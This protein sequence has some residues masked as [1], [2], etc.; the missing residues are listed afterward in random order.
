MKNIEIFKYIITSLVFYSITLTPIS[1]FSAQ[2]IDFYQ[3]PSFLAAQ[4]PPLVM[5]VMGKNHKLFYEAYN[6]ASDLN[7]DGTIDVGYCGESEPFTDNNHNDHWDPGEPFTDRNKDGKW[8]GGFDYYGY[9]DSYKC[10]RYSTSKK[11]FEPVAAPL[12]K[13]QPT[14][15][16]TGVNKN[17]WSGDFLNYLTMSR[18][19]TLRKVLYGG[20]RSKDSA[21][22]TVLERVF[23]PQDAHSWGKEYKSIAKDGYDIR[24]YTPLLLPAPN[25]RHLFASTTLSDSGPPVLRVLPDN[26]HRIWSWVAKEGPVVDDTLEVKAG[27]HPKHPGN[28][29]EFTEFVNYYT[30]KG[31]LQGRRTAASSHFNGRIDGS[32][33]PFGSKNPYL[34]LF[35]GDLNITPSNEGFYQF[36]VCGSH[37]VEV[38]ID[39]KFTAG[40][41]PK[42]DKRKCSAYSDYIF[43]SAGLHKVEFRHENAYPSTGNYSLKWMM[44]K[45]IGALPAIFPQTVPSSSF[46]SDGDG[47]SDLIQTIFDTTNKIDSTISDYIVRIEVCNS[48]LPEKNCKRYPEGSFKPVGL[49]QKYGED[50]KMFFGLMTGSYDKNMS[51][52]V[53]RKNISSFTDE[54]NNK[55]GQFQTPTDGGIIETINKLRIADFH[56]GS[57]TYRK[58]WVT[59]RPMREAEFIDWGNPL[60][61]MMYETVRYF[62]GKP[63]PTSIFNSKTPFFDNKLKLP[64][65]A[66]TSPYNTFN[67]CSPPFMLLLSDIYPTFDSDQLP[68]SNFTS[69]RPLPSNDFTT[70]A[71]NTDIMNVSVLA[72]KISNEETMNG[73]FFIGQNGVTYDGACT[74]KTITSLGNIRG[75]CPEEPTKEGSYYAAAVAYY[76][77]KY[78]INSKAEGAQRITTYSVALASP[79][80]HINIA[81]NTGTTLSPDIHQVTLIP[82]AKSI[83]GSKI[84]PDK[85]EFQPTNTIVDFFVEEITPTYGKFRVNFED[86]EQGA[87]HDM[88]AIV[89]YEYT[90]KHGYV[91]IT[92]KCSYAAGSMIQH[93]G[94]IISGTTNDGIYLEVRDSD[95]DALK[96][97]DYFLDTPPGI[98]PGGSGWND[99]TALPI[100]NSR[101]FYPKTSHKRTAFIKNPL[102]YAAKW[103]GFR[104][105]DTPDEDINN[106]KKLDAGEDLNHNGK[107]DYLSDPIPNI[108]SEWDSDGNNLPD[109]YFYVVS[110]LKLEE[111]LSQSFA[112]MLA[113]ASSGSAASIISN[114]RSGEGAVYQSVFYPEFKDSSGNTIKWAGKIQAFLVDQHGNMRVDMYRNNSGTIV[115]DF[116]GGFGFK[117]LNLK[118]EDLNLNGTRDIGLDEDINHNSVL[119]PGEDLNHN[120]KLDHNIDEPDYD[121]DG[122][123]DYRD[124]IAVFQNGS[125]SLWDDANENGL[126]DD[127]DNIK[128]NPD[129][130]SWHNNSILDTED[131]N[132]NGVLDRGEDINGNHK[133]DFEDQNGNHRLD[134]ELIVSGYTPDKIQY[135]WSSQ[136]WLDSFLLDPLTQRPY[137]L[138]HYQRYI[139]TF[140]DKDNDMIADP[141][142]T[143]PFSISST[144]S[145]TDLMD[146]SKIFPYLTL[147]PSFNDRPSWVSDIERSGKKTTFLPIQAK[148]LIEYIR[149]KDQSE[150]SVG[151]FKIP[152]M[153]SRKYH[154]AGISFEHTWRLGDAI[155]SSPTLVGRPT[156]NYHLLYRDTSYA[157]FLNRYLNRR[158]VVYVGSNDGMIHAFNA[159]FYDHATKTFKTS[160]PEPFI[161]A[162]SN[163]VYDP[164]EKFSDLDGN[165]IYSPGN[166]TPYPLGSELWAY[167]PFNLLPHLYWL[168]EK[169]Y[170]HVY[171]ND[172]SPKIFDAKIFQE[173]DDHPK[174][175]GTVMVVGMNFGGGHIYADT[176]KNDIVDSSDKVMTSAYSIFD[177]TNPESPPKI[178]A[179]IT[180]PRQGYTTCYPAVIPMRSKNRSGKHIIFNSNDWYLVFG[181][182]PADEHG[183]AAS[184]DSKG[185]VTRSGTIGFREI[186]N[187]GI[188]R[189]TGRLFVLN[190]NALT[191]PGSEHVEVIDENGHPLHVIPGTSNAAIEIFDGDEAISSDDEPSFVSQPVTVDYN[192]NF[193]C[194]AVYF[195][196]II[197]NKKNFSWEGQVKRL[198]TG[199]S[200]N[201]EDWVSS[202]TVGSGSTVNRADNTLFD[203]RDSGINHISQP[204]SAPVSVSVGKKTTFDIDGSDPLLH[205][206]DDFD[207]QRW[208][209]FGTGRLM[210]GEDSLDNSQQSYYGIK[211][212]FDKTNGFTWEEVTL[213]D[214]LNST[215][216]KIYNGKIVKNHPLFSPSD[217]TWAD[218]IHKIEDDTY[219]GW[220]IDFSHN[221]ERSLSQA[222]LLSGLLTFTTF[223]PSTDICSAEGTSR[224]YSRW[225]Q[226]GTAYFKKVFN[227]ENIFTDKN[228]NKIIDSGELEIAGDISLGKGLAHSPSLHTGR[229]KGGTAFVQTS[230]G[231]ILTINMAEGNQNKSQKTSWIQK[232]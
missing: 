218:M 107:I 109:N 166:Q 208:I 161:D 106:N 58:G 53:L 87:D 164:G 153:R 142:E 195:G 216:I 91:E 75:L 93:L 49:L 140:I 11:R 174:G 196:T 206:I 7:E 41:Y 146:M 17:Y 33:N 192:L 171:Y 154:P 163:G 221:G 182:G 23:I 165:N 4:A 97:N 80:P 137:D 152:A 16:C 144:P 44:S 70:G 230:K 207:R 21:H 98:I 40:S 232:R 217:A 84:I 129:I 179:E 201:T 220:F 12:Y 187:D 8:T 224:I 60:A 42:D 176:N 185:S 198:I 214:L 121:Q 228:R 134:S 180:L 135:L 36:C 112:Q 168:S 25:R 34:N 118:N 138:D 202:I 38:A 139:F 213:S 103:G 74:E 72:E 69:S 5:L 88:D 157:H 102:Y 131:T 6:D 50:E 122:L 226:T 186:L 114:S 32:G 28:H 92:T 181:S 211:E 63:T 66:W 222:N 27:G 89:I 47:K 178:L 76:G 55:T 136:D 78:D 10:Y 197:W 94:Y 145:F 9:F 203:L 132:G 143:L 156:E 59:T 96:D 172:L 205:R 223:A 225:F 65:P 22:E 82:F 194:D 13:G 46:D 123:L 45:T 56:Y 219:R 199:D 110:P 62:A 160:I 175:W 167:I 54:I 26:I 52:G 162:N 99:H 64:K 126:K 51:G 29:E 100:T 39:G 209:F 90:V 43:L 67:A 1:S 77:K 141:G 61:E 127:E 18:M 155:N 57:Y 86:V 20:F 111:Q 104:D 188:S 79:L 190:L 105:T 148:R 101:I 177:I 125:I 212:P 117:Q 210:V 119:D 147:Y 15:K 133:L 83:S 48:S 35:T 71:H 149:G 31:D 14:K 229:E 113:K 81:I 95:T 73:N 130:P 115:S 204:V 128:F 19:D 191:M 200:I 215:N 159:G 183:I 193:N 189:Q 68:G 120:G 173:D 3:P 169:A 170:S 37:A 124:L 30:V 108:Q 2:A 158:A 151:K 150:L 24:D 85:G 116:S 227:K 231:D 184:R